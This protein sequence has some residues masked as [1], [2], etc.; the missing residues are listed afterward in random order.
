MIIISAGVRL[1][2]SYPGAGRAVSLA[3]ATLLLNAVPTVC[4][5]DVGLINDPTLAPHYL[6]GK[7]PAM[8]EVTEKYNIPLEAVLGGPETMYPEY[9]RT[10]KDTYVL[11]P[12]VQAGGN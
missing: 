7:H 6:P 12:P 1:A 9:R 11:P 2:A 10:M 4:K 3:V 8:N 5:A